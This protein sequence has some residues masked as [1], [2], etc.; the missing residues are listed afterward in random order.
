MLPKRHRFVLHSV[1]DLEFADWVPTALCNA[2]LCP[3]ISCTL[4]ARSRGSLLLGIPLPAKVRSGTSTTRIWQQRSS[5]SRADSRAASPSRNF[6]GDGNVPL[7]CHS[8][9]IFGRNIVY[10][11]CVLTWSLLATY[12]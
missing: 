12:G 7:Q 4:V 9:S 2:L 10:L 5:V 11:F 6:C 1:H 3:C 8:R